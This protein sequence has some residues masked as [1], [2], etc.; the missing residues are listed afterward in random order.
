MSVAQMLDGHLGEHL[1]QVSAIV[2]KKYSFAFYSRAST[3]VREWYL[4]G[5]RFK[6]V[7]VLRPPPNLSSESSQLS[8]ERSSSTSSS[9]SASSNASDASSDYDEP[10][11]PITPLSNC[12]ISS[13]IDAM[14]VI[15]NVSCSMA[16]DPSCKEN[17]PRTVSFGRDG[18]LPSH[19]PA[20]N[21]WE[22][23]VL[24]VV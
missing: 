13:D 17:L 8:F 20:L 2:I 23:N 1:D 11:T 4:G 16:S 12:S 10:V 3:F 18:Y 5:S 24:P 7:Q 9:S 15:I 6:P 19:R 21:P 22:V 14:D